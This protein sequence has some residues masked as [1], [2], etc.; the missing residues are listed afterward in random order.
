MDLVPKILFNNIKEDKDANCRIVKGC[1][2]KFTQGD[3]NKI[4]CHCSDDGCQ[5]SLWVPKVEMELSFQ[6]KIMAFEHTCV[7][8]NFEKGKKKE[9]SNDNCLYG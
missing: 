1:H 8:F 7:P 3:P 5:W 4:Q 9:K 6:V 2:L